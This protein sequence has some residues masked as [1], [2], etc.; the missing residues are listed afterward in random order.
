[1]SGGKHK[2]VGDRERIGYGNP[3]KSSQFVKG[4]SGNPR[5]RPRRPRTVATSA[6]GDSQFDRMVLEEMD[7]LVAVR[8]GETIEKTSVLRAATRAILLK[9]AKGDVKAYAAATTKLAAIDH[10]RRIEREELLGVVME[11][12]ERT[13]WELA[14]RKR[15]RASGPEIIPHPDDKDWRRHSQG[16]P[17]ARPE[18]GSGLC[19]LDLACD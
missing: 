6:L 15:Q 7:R 14:R 5:G 9:A 1:M 16:P 10:R 18:D 12:K 3:P 2:S 13:G 11:Y 17:H 19:R 4:Q 8:E